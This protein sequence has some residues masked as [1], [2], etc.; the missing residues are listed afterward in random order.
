MYATSAFDF[1]QADNG[2]LMSGNAFVRGIFLIFM[3]PQII[4]AGRNWFSSAR[5]PRREDP[6]PG[7]VLLPAEPGVFD[8]PTETRGEEEPL[9]PDP[10]G[11][12]AAFA[13]D[14]VFL[15]WS[16]LVD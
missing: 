1:N 10:A 16:L 3:F 14:L 9:V 5:S 7:T 11:G 8:T 13:F 6:G 15:R 12:K 2:W 4:S